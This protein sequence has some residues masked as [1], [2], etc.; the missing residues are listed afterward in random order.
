MI[1]HKL[2]LNL[3]A[4]AI[5]WSCQ[6]SSTVY[7]LWLST[8][9][10]DGQ[11]LK[12][13]RQHS[14]HSVMFQ[15]CHLLAPA[16]CTGG[17][18]RNLSETFFSLSMLSWLLGQLTLYLLEYTYKKFSLMKQAWAVDRKMLKSNQILNFKTWKLYWFN[19]R[20]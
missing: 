8:K 7:V 1:P 14:W 15:S 10:W 2:I 3:A 11:R 5:R 19:S 6:F 4:A 20:L 9:V 16:A 18:T 13:S 12:L 17:R